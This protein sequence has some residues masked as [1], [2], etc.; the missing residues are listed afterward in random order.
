MSDRYF[1][2]L[3]RI[4][5]E[6]LSDLLLTEPTEKMVVVVD[7]RDSGGSLLPLELL[8]LPPAISDH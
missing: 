5:R 8:C 7:V 6:R 3:N 4:S 2:S 1:P